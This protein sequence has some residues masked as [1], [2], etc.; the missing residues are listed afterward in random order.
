MTVEALPANPMDKLPGPIRRWADIGRDPGDDPETVFRKLLLVLSASFFGIVV[1]VLALLGLVVGTPR[2]VPI[3][4]AYVVITAVGLVFIAQTKRLEPFRTSQI[5]MYA[6]FPVFQQWVMGG[7]VNSSAAL[8]FSLTAPIIAIVL[9][10]VGT[11]RLWLS[12]FAIAAI[13]TGVLAPFFRERAE[14]VSMSQIGFFFV[15]TAIAIAM[16]SVLPLAFFVQARKRLLEEVTYERR[17]ADALLRDVFPDSIV[18]RLKDGERPIADRF[19]KVAVLFADIVGSTPAVET[20]EPGELI[21]DL[22]DLFTTFDR[23]ASERDLEKVR[24]IGDAYMVMSGAPLPRPDAADRIADMALAMRE[25]AEGMT[26]A[27]LPVRLRYG[28]DVGPVVGGVIGETKFHYDVYG[29]TVNA[30]SRMESHGEADRIQVT[31]RAQ[32]VLAERFRLV[33]RGELEVKGKGRM[34]TFFLEGQATEDPLTG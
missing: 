13:V 24:T 22:N 17:R 11:W 2:A 20:M 33:P 31:E 7:Y 3:P 23:L 30:A 29:D 27:G 21:E 18:E 14:L 9:V 5:V 10:G 1:A 15:Y 26:F 32:R 28:M 6:T 25:A 19:D 4:A 12:V 34:Q 16:F 8:M